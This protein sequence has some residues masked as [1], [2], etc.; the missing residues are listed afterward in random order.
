MADARGHLRKHHLVC[1][2]KRYRTLEDSPGHGGY[3]EMKMDEV[4]PYATPVEAD[5]RA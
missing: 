1:W 3:G 5:A 4:R 2:K